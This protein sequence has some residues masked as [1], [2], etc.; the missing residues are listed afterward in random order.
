MSTYSRRDFFRTGALALLA[1][2]AAP[3][4]LAGGKGESP[5]RNLV[6]P[7]RRLRVAAIG[8]AGR[9]RSNIY[10]LIEAGAEIVALCDVD[11]ARARDMFGQFPQLPRYKDYRRMLEEM[12]R[13]IDAVAIS[14]PDHMHFPQAMAAIRRGK[15]VYVEKPLTHTIGEARALKAA[16]AKAGVVTIMGNQGHANDGTRLLKEWIDAGVIGQVREIHAWTNRPIWPQGIS[17][18]EEKSAPSTIDWNLWLGVAPELGYSPEIAPFKWRAFWDFGCGALGDM[19]CHILD[20]AFWALNLTGPVKVSAEFT[21]KPS[22]A[23]SAPSSAVVTYEFP[24]RGPLAPV[25]LVWYEGKARPPRPKGLPESAKPGANG[26]V[27]YGDE[28]VL[29]DQS[30]YGS[31]PRLLPQE[32]MAEFNKNRPPRIL[33]RVPGNN[34][35]AEWVAACHGGPAPGSRIDG[36]AADLTEMTLLGNLAMRTQPIEWD[37]VAGRCVGAPEVD[38]LIH[39]NYRDF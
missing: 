7:G 36:Y 30:V 32:R 19:G 28:G 31:S 39:K 27:L 9:G 20:G 12:D 33:P 5:F 2:G 16:V 14:T 6:P 26:I 38:R 4:L 34:P 10:G 8:L 35:H 3:R 22:D 25:K 17:L 23:V 15:H 37:P 18:P 29:I 24:A 21:R 13:E 11:F 1:A